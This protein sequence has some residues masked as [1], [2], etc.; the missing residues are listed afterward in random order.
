ME[1]RSEHHSHHEQT[2][3][4]DGPTENLELSAG[5]ARSTVLEEDNHPISVSGSRR[6]PVRDPTRP[7]GLTKRTHRIVSSSQNLDTRRH[8]E[9]I[10][11]LIICVVLVCGDE[12]PTMGLSMD[13]EGL[14]Y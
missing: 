2:T 7:G 9:T 3:G 13:E 8:E 12:C 1:F 10:D 4:S 11:W 6:S 14:L 5:E